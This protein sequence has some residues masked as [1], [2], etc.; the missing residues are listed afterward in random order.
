MTDDKRYKIIYINTE[1]LNIYF[2][3]DKSLG[4][5]SMDVL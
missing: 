4:N 2:I 5:S 1:L 3:A